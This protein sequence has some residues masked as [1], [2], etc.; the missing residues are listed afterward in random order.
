ML[1]LALSKAST[2]SLLMR[3]GVTKQHKMAFGA[4]LAFV[5]L[6]SVASVFALALQCDLSQPW[7]LAGTQCPGTVSLFDLELGQGILLTI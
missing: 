4:M 1:S 2:A 7:R 6:W 5:A 3:L